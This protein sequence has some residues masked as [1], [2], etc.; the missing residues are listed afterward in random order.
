ME[1]QYESPVGRITLTGDGIVLTGLR[2]AEAADKQSDSSAFG[3]VRR[4]LDIYFSGREPGFMPPMKPQGTEFQK[5]V[6]RELLKIPYG[7]T[8]S[9]GEVARRVGCRSAQAVGGAVGRN[10]IAVI[11]PCHRVVGSD[12]SLTGYAYG[13]DC[14][15]QL[16]QLEKFG[17][18]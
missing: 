11:I 17:V 14:K 7:H 9:Y 1:Y 13:L 18:F 16:L 6:W 10:P 2:F 8:V 4:W 3:E 15:Q 12:G 5:R